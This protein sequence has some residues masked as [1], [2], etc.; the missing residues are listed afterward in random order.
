M[1][2]KEGVPTGG[3]SECIGYSQLVSLLD[4]RELPLQGSP[5]HLATKCLLVRNRR[6]S[7]GGKQ[8]VL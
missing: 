3:G 7:L 6:G 4:W 5:Q 2:R 1:G 8:K